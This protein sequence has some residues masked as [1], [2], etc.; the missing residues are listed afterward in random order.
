MARPTKESPQALQAFHDYADMGPGRS[1]RALSERYQNEINPPTRRLPTLLN[2]SRDFDWQTRL[3]DREARIAERAEA[4]VATERE[5]W[6]RQ[7]LNEARALHSAGAAVL[8]P[9]LK[10]VQNGGLEHWTLEQL[11]DVLPQAIRAIEV[12][13]KEERLELG[14]VTERVENEHN[15]NGSE[16]DSRIARLAGLREAA[17][18]PVGDDA[19]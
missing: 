10:K 19:P 7:R 4:A 18:H 6:K 12:G 13:H 11:A 3:M 8:K 17:L 15:F 5:E 9:F 1:I 16:L 2:W 14:E